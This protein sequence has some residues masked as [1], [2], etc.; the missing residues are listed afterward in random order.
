MRII[1][2]TS[3]KGGSGKSTL[4]ASLAVAAAKDKET[5]LAIDLD[6]QATLKKWGDR[7]GKPAGVDTMGCDPADLAVVL[8][9]ARA[10]G[11][12]SL[13]IIDTP[14]FHGPDLG[15][16]LKE[17]ELCLVPVRP[18]INDLEAVQLTSQALQKMGRPFAFVVNAAKPSSTNRTLE[19]AQVLITMGGWLVPGFVTDRTEFLDAM[20]V[21]LGVAEYAPN[22]KGTQ[23]VK[24]MWTWV[25][26]T[27]KDDIHVQAKAA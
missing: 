10:S 21:G 25:K 22:G 27:L 13:V 2:M 4:T 15:L 11:R 26:K 8:E 24:V 3:Q 23:E 9:R 6:P 20:I 19:M 7:R 18:S 14:G 17:V 16:A 12:Y 5:V 1:S